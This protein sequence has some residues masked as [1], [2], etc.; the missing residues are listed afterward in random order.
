MKCR[1][2]PAA[3]SASVPALLGSPGGSAHTSSS[4]GYA[5]NSRSMVLSS[6]LIT[7]AT[8]DPFMGCSLGGSRRRR[9]VGR[10]PSGGSG[11]RQRKAIGSAVMP[12]DIEGHALSPNVLE[13][14]LSDEDTRAV[15]E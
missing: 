7:A 5:F 15:P 12:G 6:R 3:C 4:L 11:H 10:R 14:Q 9:H 8:A 2:F 13:V 1:R